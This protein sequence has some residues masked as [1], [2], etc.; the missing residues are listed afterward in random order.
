MKHKK[1]I[2]LLLLCVSL[3][4]ACG[5]SEEKQNTT[6]QPKGE[7]TKLVVST[8]AIGE[9]AISE[10]IIKP[11]EEANNCDIV[12]ETGNSGD[13]YTKF[14]S[15]P[16]SGIDV[17]ELSQ[18]HSAQGTEAGLFEKLDAAKVPNMANLIVP[19]A[20]M[21]KN[22]SGPAFVVNSLG[23]IYDP[24]TAGMEIKEWADLWDAKLAGKIA[25]PDMSITYGPH[26][27]YVASDYAKTDIK[28]DNGAAALKA[29]EALKPNVVKTYT[30][31]SDLANMFQ[32]GEIS[33]A[34]VGDFALPVIFKAMPDLTY[35]VPASGTYTNFNCINVS[36]N[37]KNKELAYKFVDWRISEAVQSKTAVSLNE[38][39]T[40]KNV[41]L[42]E[43]TSKNKTYGPVAERAK[44]IDS[45]FLIK[46]MNEWV[47][48]WNR[49]LN[50]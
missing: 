16:N 36:K 42:D 1:S 3:L 29:I 5:K 11:F 23:I 45:S 9:E 44:P 12:I 39:P 35:I 21:A 37:S 38:A 6:T 2:L 22:G 33:A 26:M 13:R 8:F 30:K 34:V 47:K 25:I 46:N 50:Q 24:K 31:S 49:I 15:N 17:I 7:K 41:K 40:N 20:E 10:D 4:S 18:N 27:L 28:S 19:A 14:S 43:A 48:Q 32:T